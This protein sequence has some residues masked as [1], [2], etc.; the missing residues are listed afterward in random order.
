MKN[1]AAIRKKLANENMKVSVNDIFIKCVANA[2]LKVP[3]VNSVWEG[4]KVIIN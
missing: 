4:D 2:L 1:V 3:M